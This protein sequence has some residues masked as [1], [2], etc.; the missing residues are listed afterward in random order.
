MK[1]EYDPAEYLPLREVV[2]KTLRN[3]IIRGE[4]LPGER[5]MEEK[6]AKTLEVSRTP[7]REAI[8]ML[9]LEGLV[10]ML[11][12]KGAEVARITVSD[13][14]EALEVRM[15]IEDL[16]V[17]LATMRIDEKGKR[18]LVKAKDA[19]DAALT[20]KKVETIVEK[21]ERFHDVIFE[22]TQNRRLIALAHSLRE[23]VYRYRFEYVKDF[24][25][26]DKLSREHARIT[27]AILEGDV[28]KAQQ[29]MRGHIYDQLQR[30]ME[31][32]QIENQLPEQE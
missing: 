28:V 2:F 31:M 9:E 17:R 1:L 29:S 3:A 11:P 27:E 6:L 20:G 25:S 22:A 30:I 24:T 18:E 21:D 19:F 13:L 12:R 14:Q 16:S 5:L 23:Q 26:H 10:V 8:R 15:A 32:I 7:V 4:L